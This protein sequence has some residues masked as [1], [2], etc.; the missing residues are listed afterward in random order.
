MLD[1]AEERRRI[2][3]PDLGEITR[4]LYL[5]MHAASDA[6]IELGDQMLADLDR[7]I[8]LLDFKPAHLHRARQLQLGHASGRSAYDGIGIRLDL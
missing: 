2:G 4:H 1:R 5:G 8:A 6:A 3:E 7:G